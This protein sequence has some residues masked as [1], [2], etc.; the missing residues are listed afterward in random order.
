MKYLF[1]LISS[2]FIFLSCTSKKDDT[3]TSGI[4]IKQGTW[5]ISYYWDQKDETSNFTTYTIMFAEGGVLMA[6]KGATLYT[7]TW[8]ETSSKLIINFTD[9]TLS[10]LNDDWLITE[11]TNASIKLKDDNPAQDDQLH[12][13]KN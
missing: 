3:P 4:D 8:S 5:R 11:K 6:H 13:T 2:S 7:G 10:E 12:L 1:I 9:P